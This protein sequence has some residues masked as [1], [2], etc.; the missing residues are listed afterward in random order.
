MAHE[1]TH[2]YFDWQVSTL[3]L[4]YD[5]VQ[6]L[7]RGDEKSQADREQKVQR[8]LYQLAHAVIP[9][10]YRENPSED[11]PP[12]IVML[13]TRAT[14]ARAAQIMGMTDP[15]DDIDLTEDAAG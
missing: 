10:E 4:A 6:P 13:M 14:I 7:E 8:E 5:T 12:E 11:F 1:G 15:A 2:S 9:K 3:M